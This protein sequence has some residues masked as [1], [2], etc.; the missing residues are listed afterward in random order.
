MPLSIDL[1]RPWA[2]LALVL[3]VPT[4]W[5]ATVSRTSASR[6]RQIAGTTL[7]A[8]A[9]TALILAVAEARLV[10]SSD[11]VCVTVLVD[12]SK[13][14]D[15]QQRQ[16]A[17]DKLKAQLRG[18][19]ENHRVAVIAF[20]G[21]SV[22]Q[23]LPAD[24]PAWPA[25]QGEFGR[26]FTDI[27]QAI[28]L[29][30]SVAPQ[31]AANRIV[32]LSDG[33]DT[34]A[35]PTALAAASMARQVNV[36]IDV[37][38][39]AAAAAGD[40]RVERL[41]IDSQVEADQPFVVKAVVHSERAQA[42]RVTMI[43]RGQMVNLSGDRDRYYI[44]VPLKRGTNLVEV[45]REQ[46]G[47]G[48]F[49]DYE[50]VVEPVG[51]APVRA[52][53]R[54]GGIVRVME[55]AGVMIVDGSETGRQGPNLLA[56]LR[57][58]KID[59]TLVDLTAF[60]TSLIQLNYY[61]CLVLSDVP[62]D[63]LS[64][65]QMEMT[66]QWVE[67]GGGLVWVGGEN[68]FGPGGYA[69]TPIE[70]A[71]PV[72]CDVKRRIE[73]ASLALAIA[74]D[75]SGSM[76]APVT[77]TQTKMDL[78]NNGAAEAVRLLNDDDEAGIVMVDTA[79]KWITRPPIQRMRPSAKKK[80]ITAVLANQPGGGGI[81]CNTALKAALNA[82][83]KTRAMSKHIILFADVDDSEQ[84]EG[85]VEMV[86]DAHRAGVTVSSIGLGRPRPGNH[87]QFLENVAAAGGGKI[88]FTDD[89]KRLPRIFV[90][91]VQLRSRNAFIEP[92]DGIA[93]TAV[94]MPGGDREALDPIIRGLGAM[95]L[96]RGQVAGTLKDR[97]TLL[98]HGPKAEDPLLAKWRYG[99]GKS[100]A[101]TSDAKGKWAGQWVSW[102]RFAQFWSQVVRWASRN[103][104]LD[105]PVTSWA[106]IRGQRGV[107]VADAID[108]NGEPMDD[109]T[110]H[111]R[112]QSARPGG[113][114]QSVEL[115]PT[116][117]G[118]YEGEFHASD[119]GAYVVTTID[120]ERGG[121]DATGAVMSYSPEYHQLAPDRVMLARIAETSGG[122]SMDRLADLF[123]R[124]PGKAFAYTPI[125][126]PL[127]ALAMFLFFTDI[128]VRRL[129][130]PETVIRW[131]TPARRRQTDDGVV[132]RLR[133][134]RAALRAAE[135]SPVSVA[136]A[137]HTQRR[138]RPP[139][140]PAE[141]DRATSTPGGSLSDRLR[142]AKQRAQQEMQEKSERDR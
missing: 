38:P 103:Q 105:S 139:E 71:S 69:R 117:S 4:V 70:E 130:L 77:V 48:G 58:M 82:L 30:L 93:P 7:R 101:W 39:L 37:Y 23:Q 129:V 33:N 81:Y 89:P 46:I 1:L 53:N 54:A 57:T 138:T 5:L 79:Y 76:G 80:L 134:R 32:L 14:V 137:E 8:I 36:P 123:T 87:A 42:A 55:K 43:R 122:R 45:S 21:R 95:P 104:N 66:R 97:A 116:G 140:P 62:A 60:P 61:D 133:R 84:Q 29:A 90:R 112:V 17:L 25:M 135:P 114:A 50:V 11:K 18:M 73:R 19:A 74:I 2:L 119:V 65:P 16:R 3:L 52:N 75:Q 31:D 132:G 141:P 72:S 41:L 68:S 35:E 108:E 12:Q 128:V 125:A 131:L 59:A 24:G 51:R 124:P 56:A 64:I 91:D 136:L 94:V 15:P 109:L 9:V 67:A 107:I 99:L 98:I 127:V 96:L 63:A 83:E 44:T 115:R 20:G 106:A 113:E 118:R 22:L 40:V 88:Y 26:D 27:G 34:V 120:E 102:E 100:V 121:M 111:A 13:S 110:L 49:F 10:R 28:R 47:N 85:C 92:L 78:A 142:A 86:A 126:L 6:W